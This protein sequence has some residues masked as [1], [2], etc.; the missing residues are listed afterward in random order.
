MRPS[1]SSRAMNSS[2]LAREAEH[3]DGTRGPRQAHLEGF[4]LH[5]NVWVSGNDQVGLEP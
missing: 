5:A 4:D 3:M 1:R 2:Q